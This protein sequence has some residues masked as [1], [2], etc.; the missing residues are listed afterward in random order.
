MTIPN[1]VTISGIIATVF[2]V[3]G[4]L[5]NYLV[6]M[7]GTVLWAMFSDVLDGFLARRLNQQTTLGAFLDPLRDRLLLAAVIGNLIFLEGI[8]FVFNKW[9]VVILTAECGI[10]VLN[11]CVY[12]KKRILIK[13]HLVG[14]LRQVGHL[15]LIG[16]AVTNLYL[17]IYDIELAQILK[18]M[19]V[20][21]FATFVFYLCR[22]WTIFKLPA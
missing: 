7:M 5:S 8:E 19:A 21:S 22:A 6:V 18:L 3:L 10:F 13:V 11:T 14:K 2:Y 12:A 9:V 16:F 17:N 4:Y 1:L 20:L 15:I